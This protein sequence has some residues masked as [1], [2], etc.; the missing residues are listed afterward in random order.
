MSAQSFQLRLGG[1]FVSPEGTVKVRWLKW[2]RR[3]K[4]LKDEECRMPEASRA[5]APPW[6][7]RKAACEHLWHCSPTSLMWVTKRWF[8]ALRA[9]WQGFAFIW[10]AKIVCS[11]SHFLKMTPLVEPC[12]LK[13]R[14]TKRGEGE[15]HTFHWLVHSSKGCSSW[16]WA[17]QKPGASSWS[18]TRMQWAI[19]WF[20]LLCHNTG[21]SYHS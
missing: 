19:F 1:E 21:P 15:A 20:N 14:F 9:L 16:S 6:T 7:S 10:E 5:L 18:P 11:V 12:C 2:R 17:I 4:I 13:G 8:L 3:R